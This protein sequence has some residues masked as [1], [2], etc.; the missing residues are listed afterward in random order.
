MTV[1]NF[2]TT[3]LWVPF[4]GGVTAESRAAVVKNTQQEKQYPQT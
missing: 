4:C 2:H 1:I 3:D